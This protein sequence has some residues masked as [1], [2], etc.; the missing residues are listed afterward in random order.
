D[1]VVVVRGLVM[2]V[3]VL[4][5]HMNLESIRRQNYERRR[6]LRLAVKVACRA[7]LLAAEWPVFPVVAPIHIVRRAR[8]AAAHGGRVRSGI[9]GLEQLLGERPLDD[10]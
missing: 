10:L 9:A 8:S 6:P 7:K 2:S 4:R 5:R 1:I 3:H